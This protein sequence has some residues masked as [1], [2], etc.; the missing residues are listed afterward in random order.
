[1]QNYKTYD[2]SDDMAP[3][4]LALAVLELQKEHMG[5]SPEAALRPEVEVASQDAAREMAVYAGANLSPEEIRWFMGV[6]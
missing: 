1:M 4:A 2:D 6:N 3:F 5:Y